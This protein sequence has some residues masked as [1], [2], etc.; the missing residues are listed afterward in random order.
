MIAVTR[1]TIFAMGM[2]LGRWEAE[3]KRI[4]RSLE[5]ACYTLGIFSYW[6]LVIFRESLSDNL[7]WNGGFYWYPFIFAAPALVFL[8]CR[9]FSWTERRVP[10]ALRFFEIAGECSLEIYLIHIVAF[11]YIHPQ[12]N[13]AWPFV[14][15]A[16]VLCGY[17]YHTAIAKLA[18]RLSGALRPADREGE[19]PVK[20]ETAGKKTYIEFLRIAAAFLV[21]VNH[22]NSA[23]FLSLDP[24]LT[25][26]CSLTYFF[27]CKIAVPVF[28]FIMGAL[29]L[30]KEDA[31]EKSKERLL[32][33]SAVFLA[34]SLCYYVYYSHRNGTPFSLREFLLNLPKSP[35]TNAFWYLY[36]YLA[37]L[38]MLPI[39][40]KL[41]QA[42]D[43]RRLEYLL[44]LSLGVCGTAPLISVFYPDFALYYNFTAGL[45]GAYIGQVLLGYYIEEYVPMTRKVF[46][47]CLCGFVLSIAFQTAG[48]FLLCQQSPH[49]YV[50]DNRTLITI[51]ASAACF[52]VCVKYLFTV[53][54]PGPALERAVRRLGALTF[55]IYL[56]GDLMISLSARVHAALQGRVHVLAAMVL[57]ELFI[58]AACALAAAALRLVPFL[59]KWL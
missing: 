39:L 35:A 51:T 20:P 57:W 52:Y 33:V 43:R 41:S 53:H 6:L 13:K 11:D 23:I 58:F 1:F 30:G 55:G 40:Q 48:T 12:S 46:W 15:A 26:F 19:R 44:F 47:T 59:R 27:I 21:I 54:P 18:P 29:L 24:C 3:G 5:L 34:G 31:P 28:L 16:M 37:L 32:R 49:N 25:W 8:L 10:R 17:I 2:A 4:S 50:L 38:C 22:T 7:L 14:Y 45:T 56:L 42:L 36:L 9:I